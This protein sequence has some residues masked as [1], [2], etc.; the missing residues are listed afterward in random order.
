MTCVDVKKLAATG[1]L[2]TAFVS[3]AHAEQAHAVV[4]VASSGTIVHNTWG[5]CVRTK[6]IDNHEACNEISLEDRTVYFPFGKT[7]LTKEAKA[8]LN[9]LVAKIK[10]DGAHVHNA[11][12]VGYAD[13]I[14]NPKANMKLS[15]KRAEAVRSYL[16]AKGIVTSRTVKVRGEGESTPTTD[17][18]SDLPRAR[19]IQCLQGDRRVEVVIDYSPEVVGSR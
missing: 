7:T 18:P 6:W 17:C 3:P 14:G 12:A 13:R 8:R 10:A 9:T 11:Q 19:L 2:L 16:V 1:L 4:R 5:N 15:L